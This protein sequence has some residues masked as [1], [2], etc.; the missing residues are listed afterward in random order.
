M[1]GTVLSFFIEFNFSAFAICISSFEINTPLGYFLFS[2]LYLKL[3]IV[4]LK[5]RSINFSLVAGIIRLWCEDISTNAEKVFA[6]Y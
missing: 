3:N 4:R 6:L 1:K 2:F 5:F